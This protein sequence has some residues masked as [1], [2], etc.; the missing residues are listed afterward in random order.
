MLLSTEAGHNGQTTLYY[1][2]GD[3]RGTKRI[4]LV[5]SCHPLCYNLH[6][7]GGSK[8][9]GSLQRLEDSPGRLGSVL[10]LKNSWLVYA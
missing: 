3:G 5:Y 2:L 7:V 9:I 8:R 10:I 6:N 4:L 1:Y